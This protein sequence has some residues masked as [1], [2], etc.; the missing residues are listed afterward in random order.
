MTAICDCE[1]LGDGAYVTFEG[2]DSVILTAN[3]HDPDAASDT[4]YLGAHEL[5]T[6]VRAARQH[7]HKFGDDHD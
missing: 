6:L 4:V 7:G 5:K 2:P 3:H 1:H